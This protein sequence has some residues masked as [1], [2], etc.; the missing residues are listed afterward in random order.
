MNDTYP[1]PVFEADTVLPASVY[2]RV[3]PHA[4]TPEALLAKGRTITARIQQVTPEDRLP[5]HKQPYYLRADRSERYLVAGTVVNV[6][7]RAADSG[8]MFEMATVTGGKGVG[9]PV[10]RHAQTHVALY[11]LDGEAELWLDGERFVMKKGDFASVPEGSEHGFRFC[12]HRTKMM[13]WYAGTEALAAIRALGEPTDCHV[14]PDDAEV[15]WDRERMAAAERAGDIAFADEMFPELPA[16]AITRATLPEDTV[17]YTLAADEGRKFVGGPEYFALL[18]SQENTGGKFF[19]VMSQGPES[20]MIPRHYHNLHTENFFCVDGALDMIVNRSRVTLSPGDFASVPAGAIHAYRMA[21]PFT[22][23]MGFLTPGL[24]QNF[25]ETLGESGYEAN[26]Y[27]REPHQ[28]RFDRVLKE[29]ESLDLVVIEEQ[30]RE[31]EA[32]EAERA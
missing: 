28:L 23:F 22:R 12:A 8:D 5:G 26:V 17:P 1:W 19:V 11:L 13:V 30:M 4:E 25:F 15:A 29:L 2:D 14:Q 21:C 18:A 7:A 32:A 9:Q 16:R 3:V 20:E 31:I 27:P 6:L 10:H 24:F